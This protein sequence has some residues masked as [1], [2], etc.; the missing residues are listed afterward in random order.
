MSDYRLFID[1]PV[2]YCKVDK[3]SAR[4]DTPQD[5][6]MIPADFLSA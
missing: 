2:T 4:D 3:M 6:K 5:H 1:S